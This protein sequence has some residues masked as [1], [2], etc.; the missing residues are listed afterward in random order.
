MP[1][2]FPVRDDHGMINLTDSPIA[3]TGDT[4]PYG[5]HSSPPR[6]LIFVFAF[7]AAAVLLV[8]AASREP[9]I[10]D[11]DSNVVAKRISGCSAL[12]ASSSITSAERALS[13]GRRADAYLHEGQNTLAIYDL[14]KAIELEPGDRFH[15]KRLAIAHLANGDTFAEHNDLDRA[16]AA[17]TAALAADPS[18][19]GALVARAGIS[20]KRNDLDAAFADL[21]K[22][23]DLPAA[24]KI[25]LASLYD[26]EGTKHHVR[27]EFEKALQSYNE[28]ITLDGGNL[29]IRLHRANALVPLQRFDLALK[30]FDFVIQANPGQSAAFLGRGNVYLGQRRY[31]Q[32]A[33]DFSSGLEI[34]PGDLNLK[35]GRALAFEAAGRSEE[36]RR[37]FDAVLDADP[38]NSIAKAGSI[39]VGGVGFAP[40]RKPSSPVERSP[41]DL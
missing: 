15:R 23:Q 31:A 13:Y 21:I 7:I 37:D 28:A 29:E 32:A 30:D 1:K 5:G 22:V 6:P 25:V 24:Y 17:Y 36:A 9:L 16:H 35:L 10:A 12:I 26:R 11:C 3:R 33:D 2:S 4:S 27:G 8:S 41:I 38:S 19:V 40:P 20:I 39:R 18:T 14:S 34:A